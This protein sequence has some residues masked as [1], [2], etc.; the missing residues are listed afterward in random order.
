M[1]SLTGNLP[2]DRA[3]LI[4]T[5]LVARMSSDP[6]MAQLAGTVSF[7]PAIVRGAWRSPRGRELARRQAF[8]EGEPY[9]A[10]RQPP[11]MLVYEKFRQELFGGAPS[12]EQD[13]TIWQGVNGMADAMF[14][15]SLNKTQMLQLALAWKGSAGALGWA[16]VAPKLAAPLRG[17]VAY[18]M[19][20]RYVWLGR[21]ADAAGMFR[22]SMEGLPADAPLARLAR[23]ELARVT[24]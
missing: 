1:G 13:E 5:T 15:G 3:T 22:T 14:T 20:M 12:A 21:P 9:L 4:V 19:G 10:A 24:K 8:L 17:P 16:G 23:A 11:V 18:L 6:L 7:A 2:D